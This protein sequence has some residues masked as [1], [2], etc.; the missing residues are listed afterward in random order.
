MTKR[1]LKPHARLFPLPVVLTTCVDKDG[2]PNVITLAWVGVVCSEPP[3]I[4][5]S[6]RPHRYSYELIRESKEF[7]V[8]IP[9]ESIVR[10]VDICGNV[11]GREVDKFALTGLTPIPSRKIK[12]PLIMECPYNVECIVVKE[13]ELGSHVMFI[14]EVVAMHIDEDILD[15][16]GAVDYRKAKPFSYCLAGY[17]TLDRE[18]GSHGYTL[19]DRRGR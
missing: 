15:E 18:I 1:M 11:S 12:P 4:S 9:S 2:N 10:E 3:Q 8:N 13:L 14:G 5:I 19:K 7:T 16:S 6:V 17:W